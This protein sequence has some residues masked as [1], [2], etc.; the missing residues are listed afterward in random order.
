MSPALPA[1]PFVDLGQ[2]YAL[3]RDAIDARIRAVLTHGRFI[4]GPEV[5]EL[6]QALAAHC[7]AA[8]AIGVS[9]GTTALQIA[10]MALDIGVGDEVITTPFTFIATGEALSLLGARPV[11]VDIDPISFN[12]DPARIEAAITSR[13]RAIL[14]VSLFGHCADL[15][16]INAL[17]AAHGLA[18]I[19]DAAQSFGAAHPGGRSCASTVLATTSFFPSKPLGGYGDGGACFTSDAALAE[20][21]RRIRVHGQAERYR[22]A[23]IGVNGRLDTLQ[24]AILLAKLPHLDDELAA[25]QATAIRYDE[26]I[27]AAGLAA[28]GV[29][30]PTIGSGHRSAWAQYTV[31]LPRRDAV[32]RRLATEGIPTA[33]HYPIPLHRQPVYAR[34]HGHLV[35]PHTERAAAEVLSLP[36]HPFLAAADLARIIAALERAVLE[37]A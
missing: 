22:H 21:I 23:E 7:G 24:A 33:V 36:M 17:A 8:Q 25:R 4:L 37:V 2:Q 27:A 5:A 11:F 35:L 10:L 30:T 13:T 9:D 14:P 20:R 34:D 26:A 28:H 31:R 18:V 19:E 32:A 12:L 15:D 1:L 16:T 3:Y 6:E 29:V